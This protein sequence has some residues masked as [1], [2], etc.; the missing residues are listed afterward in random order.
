[1]NSVHFLCDNLPGSET[2]VT[3][4][5]VL[6]GKISRLQKSCGGKKKKK[7]I[8]LF[9]VNLAEKDSKISKFLNSQI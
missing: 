9:W 6:K 1:M 5:I 3:L 4:H 8:W 2:L 7:N